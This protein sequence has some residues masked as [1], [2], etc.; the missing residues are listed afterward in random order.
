VDRKQKVDEELLESFNSHA[1][2]KVLRACSGLRP[3]VDISVK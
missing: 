1:I 3:S 2:H